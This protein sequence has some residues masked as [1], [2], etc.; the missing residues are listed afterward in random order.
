MCGDGDDMADAVLLNLYKDSGPE[1][2]I[3]LAVN[4]KSL[5]HSS[6][7]AKVTLGYGKL[8][9]VIT[10]REFEAMAKAGSIARPSDGAQGGA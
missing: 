4:T 3:R 6:R 7:M 1:G 5:M 9:N 10:S 8:K 2:L